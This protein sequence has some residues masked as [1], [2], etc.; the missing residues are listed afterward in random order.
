MG[1]CGSSTTKK[2]EDK[3]PVQ[4]ENHKDNCNNFIIGEIYI[5]DDEVNKEIR[6]IN[7]YEE[8]QRIEMFKPLDINKINEAEIKTCIIQINETVIPFNY[9]HI[10]QNAGKYRIKYAFKDYITKTNFMF[11]KCTSLIKLD[12]SYFKSQNVNDM[13]C[14]FL[15]CSSLNELNLLN[16]NT[17]KVTNMGHMFYKCSSLLKLNLSNF[18]TSNVIDMNCMFEGCESL[19][20]L[21]L[22]NFNV[23]KV[24]NMVWMFCDCSSLEYLNISSFKNLKADISDIFEGCTALKREN[25]ISDDKKVA[26]QYYISLSII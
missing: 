5:K 1:V 15:E 24:T 14:M 11:Y 2:K 7:S 13:E 6:I 23:Q 19:I 18:D 8:Y 26:L 10:F 20:S 4:K 16:F 17:Q 3:N 21:D 9:F 22:S 12:F 25:I